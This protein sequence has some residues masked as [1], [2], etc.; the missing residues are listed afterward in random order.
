MPQVYTSNK[1]LQPSEREFTPPP[2]F[3]KLYVHK[4]SYYIPYE[5]NYLFYAPQFILYLATRLLGTVIG[6]NA[7]GN[8]LGAFLMSRHIFHPARLDQKF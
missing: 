8:S 2:D 4:L 5:D 1:G 3:V 6:E 7:S